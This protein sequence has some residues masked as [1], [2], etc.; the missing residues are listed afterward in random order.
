LKIRLV[1]SFSLI[2]ILAVAGCAK[3]EKPTN[4]PG[5]NPTQSAYPS[6]HFRK[7]YGAARQF[8]KTKDKGDVYRKSGDYAKAIELYKESLKYTTTSRVFKAIAFDHLAMTYEAMGD[9]KEA[10]DYYEMASV[11][12]MNVNRTKD[13]QEKAASLRSKLAQQTSQQ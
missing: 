6:D 11:A 10:A 9:Y 5:N 7:S 1:A 3:Q 12:T 2:F 13:L 4:Q 8:W